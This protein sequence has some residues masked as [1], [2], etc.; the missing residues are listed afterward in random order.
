[1]Y[2]GES[3]PWLWSVLMLPVFWAVFYLSLAPLNAAFRILVRIKLA[4][5]RLPAL[6]ELFLYTF[7][8]NTWMGALI[9]FAS[10]A[11]I[12]VILHAILLRY[13]PAERR[14]DA[15]C[16]AHALSFTLML[17]FLAIQAAALALLFV[18]GGCIH[19]WNLGLLK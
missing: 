3:K 12:A 18:P 13:V 1:M 17:S 7:Y 11:V 10:S 5:N 8:G 16:L 15:L 9:V 4:G 14:T 6:A 2:E 19:N